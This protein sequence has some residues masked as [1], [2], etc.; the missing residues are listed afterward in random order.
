MARCCRRDCELEIQLM[1][2]FFFW[3]VWIRSEQKYARDER[4]KYTT[5]EMFK[6][7]CFLTL[8]QNFSKRCGLW[9]NT[10]TWLR[11]KY[12]TWMCLNPMA[13]E[14]RVWIYFI[15]PFKTN[16]NTTNEHKYSYFADT[17]ITVISYESCVYTN[18]SIIK[19]PV[20]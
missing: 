12:T 16:K 8:Y 11:R 10:R 5:F 20:R 15:M 14:T 4:L 18:I 13:S 2:C 6:P 19:H 1:Y 3:Q 7:M 9:S 17:L